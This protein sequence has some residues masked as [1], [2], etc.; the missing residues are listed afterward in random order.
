MLWRRRQK[1]R[2]NEERGGEEERMSKCKMFKKKGIGIRRL[3]RE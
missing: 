3:E 2:K 1:T